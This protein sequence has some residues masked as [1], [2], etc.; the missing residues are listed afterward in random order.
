MK[1]IVLASASPRRM[2]LLKSIGLDFDVIPSCIDENIEGKTFSYEIIETIAME[3]AANVA[4]NIDY[5]AIIIGSDTVVVIDNNILGKPKD[6]DDAEKMLKTLSGRIHSVVTSTAIID[7]ETGHFEV[8]SVTSKVEFKELSDLE[9]KKY[10]SAGESLDKA[11]AYGIQGKA[12]VFIKSI[13]GCYN[14]IVG[15][16]LYNLAQMLTKFGIEL[17]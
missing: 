7:T 16:S 15:L 9:I 11:G 6:E 17:I 4:Q 12:N 8:E 2:E 5:P 1:K 3:K 10:I 14:N 13:E